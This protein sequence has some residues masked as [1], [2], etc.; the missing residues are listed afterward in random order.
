MDTTLRNQ[1]LGI[2][3]EPVYKAQLKVI[4]SLIIISLSTGVLISQEINLIKTQY[5]T[6][7]AKVKSKAGRLR[8]IKGNIE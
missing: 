8:K 2:I 4:I 7:V 5:H 1:Y 3:P 6:T